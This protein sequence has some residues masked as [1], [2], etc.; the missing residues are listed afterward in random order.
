MELDAQA[1]FFWDGIPHY[2]AWFDGVGW[3]PFPYEVQA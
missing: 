1:S 3:I 2:F